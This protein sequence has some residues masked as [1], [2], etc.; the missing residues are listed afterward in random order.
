MGVLCLFLAIACIFDYFRYRIP[1]ELLVVLFLTGIGLHVLE[2]QLA[3]AFLFPLTAVLLMFLLYPLFKIG[4]MGAGDVKL[5]GVCA[6]YMPFQKI[7]SFLFVSLL[8]AAIFSLI[9]LIGK[10]HTKER[11]YYFAAYMTQVLRSGKWQ[12]YFEDKKTQKNA[13]ICLSGPIFLSVV[14]Y[15]GGLY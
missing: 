5:F 10:H 3:A 13:G 2:G 8:I 1:N 9:K 15:M 12:L 6:G 4:C 11:L 14:L 7:F